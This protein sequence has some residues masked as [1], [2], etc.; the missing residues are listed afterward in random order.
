MAKRLSLEQ[1]DK[2]LELAEKQLRTEIEDVEHEEVVNNYGPDATCSETF[3]YLT[4][5]F[6]QLVSHIKEGEDKPKTLVG[7][8][9]SRLTDGKTKS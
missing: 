7:K 2:A 8:S 4:V 6:R 1:I 5:L 9:V 3:L